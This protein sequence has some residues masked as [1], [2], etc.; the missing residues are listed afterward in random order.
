MLY[1]T[2]QLLFILIIASSFAFVVGWMARGIVGKDLLRNP[3]FDQTPRFD[4]WD[5]TWPPEEELPTAPITAKT[6]FRQPNS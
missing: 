5:A 1:L 6:L 4:V 3:H 2:G